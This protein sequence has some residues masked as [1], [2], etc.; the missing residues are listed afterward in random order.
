[1]RKVRVVNDIEL[2]RRLDDAEAWTA[3]A[4]VAR[5]SIPCDHFRPEFDGFGERF[6]GRVDACILDVD[7]NPS[8]TEHMGILA[9]PTTVLYR[10][11]KERARYEGPYSL[12]ALDERVRHLLR[13]GESR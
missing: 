8:A 4:Y 9:V 3:V 13:E 6:Y 1:M 10:G 7:E 12:K 5:D 2:F 11:G